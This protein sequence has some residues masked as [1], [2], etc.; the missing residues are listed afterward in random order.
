[1]SGSNPDR[2]WSITTSWPKTGPVAVLVAA[3]A[4]NAAAAAPA[5][6]RADRI[7][8]R[9]RAR[10]ADSSGIDTYVLLHGPGHPCSAHV[11]IRARNR[12]RPPHA[13]VS[14]TFPV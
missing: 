10:T 8:G 6:A 9:R 1:M 3:P 2:W 5:R 7:R 4:G 14:M 11:S 13:E 12:Q